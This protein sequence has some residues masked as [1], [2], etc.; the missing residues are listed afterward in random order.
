MRNSKISSNTNREKMKQP[1]FNIYKS[2]KFKLNFM[3]NQGLF[4]GTACLTLFILDCTVILCE[5][6]KVKRTKLILSKW[7]YYM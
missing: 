4:S 5:D 3:K 6:F 1:L 7:L 2:Y